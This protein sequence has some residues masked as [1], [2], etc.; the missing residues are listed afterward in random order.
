MNPVSWL[1]AK[2]MEFVSG[3]GQDRRRRRD[4]GRDMDERPQ[5]NS[6]GRSRNFDDDY[7]AAAGMLKQRMDVRFPDNYSGRSK[8]E[9]DKSYQY[10]ED[11]ASAIDT[12]ST[13]IAAAL[14]SGATVKQ[15]AEAGAASV[16]I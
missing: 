8:S 7:K 16:G 9:T 2:I 6:S 11:R 5:N 10:G 14:R 1:I 12:M 4:A 3:R 13:A 15:A